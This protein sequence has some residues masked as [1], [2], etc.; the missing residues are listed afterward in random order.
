VYK[1]NIPLEWIREGKTAYFSTYSYIRNCFLLNTKPY[2]CD[3]LLSVI[4][5]SVLGNISRLVD[6]ASL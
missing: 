5:S 6:T 4:Y 3:N 1:P 2:P